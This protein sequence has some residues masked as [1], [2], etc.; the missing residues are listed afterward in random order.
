MHCPYAPESTYFSHFHLMHLPHLCIS[1]S[2][3]CC[4]LFLKGLKLLNLL[5]RSRN[6]GAVSSISFSFNCRVSSTKASISCSASSFNRKAC[7]SI[8]P[9]DL[10]E[11]NAIRNIHR[12]VY[13]IKSI[14]VMIVKKHKRLENWKLRYSQ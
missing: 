9:M 3:L 14:V 1:A 4:A 11:A 12:A 10:A 6:S 13:K 8:D 2:C 7:W 5:S